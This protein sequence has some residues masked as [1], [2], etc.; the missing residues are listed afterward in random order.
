MS[1]IRYVQRVRRLDGRVDLYFRKDTHRYKL[2]SPD[3]TDA[4]RTEVE[5]I[6]ARVATIDA[7]KTPKAGTVAA[8]LR[9]YGNSAD[10]LSLGQKTQSEYQRL[11][12]EMIADMGELALRDVTPAA[13]V[14]FRDL[15]AKR[16][17]RAASNRLQVLKNALQPAIEDQRIEMDP[18]ARIKKVKRPHDLGEAH[19]VWEDTEVAA[20]IALALRRKM[21]GLARAIALARYAGFRRQTVCAIPLNARTTG[22]D[23]NGRSHKRLNWLTEKRKILA[24]KREDPRLSAIL[25]S[26]PNLALTIAYNDRNEPWKERAL[27]QSVTRLLQSLAKDS[28]ARANLTIHGLRHARGVELALAG[29]SDAEIMSQLEHATDRAAKIYRRQA[30]RRKL[31]DSAQERVDNVVTLRKADATG[32]QAAPP[33]SRL[34]SVGS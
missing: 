13:V 31:A 11:A 15:W 1:E 20:I 17:H 33:L 12:N 23:A 22:F 25:D 26:T 24:D 8:M 28:R 21:P 14:A 18:F 27:N 29:A 32:P 7:A 16:G 4:L 9:N 3:D 10:F 30:D 34:H 6:L 5:A 19:P 2:S